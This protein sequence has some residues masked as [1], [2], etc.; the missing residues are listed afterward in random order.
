VD[1][2]KDY[3]PE[4]MDICEYHNVFKLVTLKKYYSDEFVIQFFSTVH[5]HEDDVK[6]TTWMS[7]GQR[8]INTLAQFGALAYEVKDPHDPDYIRIHSPKNS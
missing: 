6:T 4:A 2:I 8:C 3:Y 5:F 1:F 7:A